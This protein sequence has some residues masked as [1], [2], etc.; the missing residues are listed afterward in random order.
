MATAVR[1][2]GTRS[3]SRASKAAVGDRSA[4]HSATNTTRTATANP[5]PRFRSALTMY[6]VVSYVMSQVRSAGKNGSSFFSSAL[7]S[8]IV[9]MGE[10]TEH[11]YGHECQGRVVIDDEIKAAIDD[12]YA[13]YGVK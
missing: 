12:Y 1:D 2:E 10:V 6:S 11:L 3:D 7:T 9:S 8:A 13:Q 4:A 5:I